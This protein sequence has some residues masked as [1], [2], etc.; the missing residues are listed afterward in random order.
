MADVPLQDLHCTNADIQQGSGIRRL[1]I[2]P[3]ADSEKPCDM[4]RTLRRTFCS[5]GQQAK[6]QNLP[7]GYDPLHALARQ[8]GLDKLGI[9][10]RPACENADYLAPCQRTD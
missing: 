2:A 3:A 4:P 7:S 5:F 10:K 6:L 8:Q 1:G 9:D